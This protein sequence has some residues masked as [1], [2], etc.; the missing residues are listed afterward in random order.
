[1]LSL[2]ESCLTPT[3]CVLVV[4]AGCSLLCVVRALSIV[5]SLRLKRACFSFRHIGTGMCAVRLLGA[6]QAVVRVSRTKW[7]HFNGWFVLL[8][9]YFS[10]FSLLFC[11]VFCGEVQILELFVLRPGL[12]AC[13]HVKLNCRESFG[14]NNTKERNGGENDSC[15]Y[16]MLD[17]LMFLVARCNA[18]VSQSTL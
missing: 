12:T 18:P 1:M 4:L 5:I 13:N 14:A 2:S 10:F 15:V 17:P 7:F 8:Q 6:M 3:V 11:R 16:E 9:Q